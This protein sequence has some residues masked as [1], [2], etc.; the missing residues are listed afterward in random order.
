ME[1]GLGRVR[2]WLGHGI[3]PARPR[4]CVA[5]GRPGGVLAE[6]AGVPDQCLPHR[7]DRLRARRLGGADP[8]DWA[9]ADAV[10]GPGSCW[11]PLM[12]PATLVSPGTWACARTLFVNG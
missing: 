10:T 7:V 8:P 12:V 4:R 5:A 6:H 3:D 1:A 9:S 11:P 2:R